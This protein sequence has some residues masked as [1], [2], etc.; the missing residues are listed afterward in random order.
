[1]SLESLITDLIEA[2][3]ANTAAHGGGGKDK[4]ASKPASK[5]AEKKAT[6]VDHVAKKFSAYLAEGGDDAKAAVK[7]IVA[8]FG[9]KRVTE[10]PEE[11]YDEAL[12]LLAQY[13]DGEDP[14]SDGESLM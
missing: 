9:A 10:I 6:T 8:K 13:V 1:M 11:N 14:L 5:P 12:D 7:K 2:L 3:K 4:P